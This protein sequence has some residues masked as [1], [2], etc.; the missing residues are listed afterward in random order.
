M[1]AASTCGDSCSTDAASRRTSRRSTAPRSH[2]RRG[3]RA[4]AGSTSIDASLGRPGRQGAGLVEQDRRC[5]R[6]SVSSGPPPLTITPRRAAREIPATIAIGAA[7]R[8]GHGVATTRTASARTG[9][10]DRSQAAAAMASV[11]GTKI[12]AYRSARRTNGALLCCASSTRRTMPGVRAVGGG[13]RGAKIEGRARVDG[14]RGDRLAFL[15]GHQPGLAGER[16]LVEHRRAARRPGRRPARL[17]RG[18]WPGGRQ[19]RRPRSGSSRVGHPRYRW[20]SCGARPR[21]AVSS[22][23]A[24]PCA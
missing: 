13:R 21:S 8:S 18:G 5:A 10:P 12:R 14:P 23:C 4:A 17:R 16:G 11:N 7:N 20:T 1:D 22:R 6:A 15:A 19:G 2:G 9:S 3:L 24:R